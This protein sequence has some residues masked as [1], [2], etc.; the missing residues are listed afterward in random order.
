MQRSAKLKMLVA[1]LEF[2]IPTDDPK[3]YLLTNRKN[4]GYNHLGEMFA[5]E[6]QSGKKE[7]KKNRKEDNTIS[8]EHG[9]TQGRK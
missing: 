4:R 3:F 5:A 8:K 2:S 9:E 6:N 7:K 1:R